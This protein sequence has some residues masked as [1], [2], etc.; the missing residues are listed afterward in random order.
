[1]GVK[2]RI[3]PKKAFLAYVVARS[4]TKLS[5]PNRDWLRIPGE[6][7]SDSGVNV[8]SVPGRR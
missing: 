3:G 7:E 4:L 8:K 5:A 2:Q 6:G 1:M